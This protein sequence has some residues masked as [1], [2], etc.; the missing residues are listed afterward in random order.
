MTLP[1]P[2]VCQRIRKLHAMVGSSSPKEAHNARDKLNHL[3]AE[4]GLPRILTAD[5]D[6]GEVRDA[7]TGAAAPA[8]APTEDDIPDLLGLILRLIE[9]HISTTAEER[10]AIAL[11]ILHCWVFDRFAVTPRLA[12]I[13]P[14]RGCGKTITLSLIELLIPEGSRTDN[15]TAAAI[16][17]ALDRRQHTVLLVDEA[18]GLDLSRNNV[19]RS[20]FNSGHRRGGSINRFVGGR[21]QRYRTFA[22]LAIAAIGMLQ[23]PLLHRAVVINMQRS[24]A[25]LRRLDETRLVFHLARQGIQKWAASCTLAADP[26]MPPVLRNRAADNWR[27]LLSIADDLGYSE[28]ARSAAVTLCANRPDEDPGI[29]LLADIRTA[30]QARGVDRIASSA[31]AEALVGL[32][33]GPWNEWRGPNDDRP[34]R[35]LT[36]GEMAGLL[37]PIGIGRKRSG[38]QVASSAVRVVVAICAR[39]SRRRGALTARRLTHRHS[40]AKS[41]SCPGREPYWCR[42]DAS[43]ASVRR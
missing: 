25:Q 8:N 42:P 13:S 7:G 34:A 10:L 22:P 30:F 1:P 11:W 39:N 18:D 41:S 17:Y 33:D 23:L 2:K 6:T 29:V 27:V 14:V 37:R 15:T 31:L 38:R 43:A 32:D 40:R 24:S 9:D 19:L 4:H 12:L 3:L 5:G 26:E 36:Q 21:P 20:L 28:A 35:K 16:Y